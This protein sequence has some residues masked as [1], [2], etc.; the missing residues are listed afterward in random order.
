MKG[1]STDCKIVQ[2]YIRVAATHFDEVP[3]DDASGEEGPVGEASRDE[4][5]ENEVIRI[6]RWTDGISEELQQLDARDR[7]FPLYAVFAAQVL[8][9][10][11]NILSDQGLSRCASEVFSILDHTD[12]AQ[13]ANLEIAD[14]INFSKQ[15]EFLEDRAATFELIRQ[16]CRNTTQRYAFARNPIQVGLAYL[17]IVLHFNDWGT[18][19][20]DKS[21]QPFRTI[22][23]YNA[24]IQEGA[25]DVQWPD[26]D[27]VIGMHTPEYLFMGGFPRFCDDYCTRMR[28]AGGL[29]AITNGPFDQSRVRRLSMQLTKLAHLLRVCN[30]SGPD[31]RNVRAEGLDLVVTV[32]KKYGRQTRKLKMDNGA[33]GAY[34]N[35]A[36]LWKLFPR[37]LVLE[38]SSSLDD[39]GKAVDELLPILHFDYAGLS[40]CC[41]QLEEDFATVPDPP[42]FGLVETTKTTESET[43][44]R[45][46]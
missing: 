39:L 22:H 38:P 19:F 41:F 21:G 23:I 42:L 14:R 11:Q 33:K 40:C 1:C 7:I 46:A 36:D 25:I 12:S 2:E 37:S 43:E 13:Q 20:A 24:A 3:G 15:N 16:A 35:M 34:V 8:L 18:L 4:I 17:E 30:H 6:P 5:S 44:K 26:L 27:F 10:I 45:N 29:R 9:D 31:A 32:M 28:A